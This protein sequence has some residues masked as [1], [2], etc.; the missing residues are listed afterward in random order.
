MG[1]LLVF[2]IGILL[3]IVLAS[4]SNT[5]SSTNSAGWALGITSTIALVICLF[6]LGVNRIVDI[7]NVGLYK[8]N[9]AYIESAF[10]NTSLTSE[11]RLKLVG[12]IQE[13]NGIITK[14]KIWHDNFWIG[15]NFSEQVG[16]L[17]MFDISRLPPAKP[18]SN[19]YLTSPDLVRRYIEAK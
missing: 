1:L 15:S 18:H 13:S 16:N 10:D 7:S 8:V 4:T 19:I 3:G 14:N 2:V 11:E 9:Q 17:K 5:Y 6:V 12:L